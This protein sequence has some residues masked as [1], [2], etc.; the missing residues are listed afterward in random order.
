MHISIFSAI[1]K[2]VGPMHF[3]NAMLRIV[4]QL[5][6]DSL[7]VMNIP[8]TAYLVTLAFTYVLQYP[9]HLQQLLSHLPLSNLS[10]I[11]CF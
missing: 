2:T 5:V 6:F 11:F 3:P 4:V 7:K 8:I 9:N 10:C 1:F